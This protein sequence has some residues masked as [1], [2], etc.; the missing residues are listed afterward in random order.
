MVVTWNSL[1]L[2]GTTLRRS[3]SVS[4]FSG[5]RKK[6]GDFLLYTRE[7]HFQAKTLPDVWN[8]TAFLY[9]Y[10][11]FLMRKEN[12]SSRCARRTSQ[13]A[14]TDVDVLCIQAVVSN[15]LQNPPHT[16]FPT[17][18][19]SSS[20]PRGGYL[21]PHGQVRYGTKCLHVEGSSCLHVSLLG[22]L[23]RFS[24]EVPRFF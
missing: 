8:V 10:I 14:M 13:R 16:L 1:P 19:Y 22:C 6:V 5:A 11:R 23:E 3:G 17:P 21:A 7:T 9:F 20:T 15:A 2:N 24:C 12:I 4:H 18:Y